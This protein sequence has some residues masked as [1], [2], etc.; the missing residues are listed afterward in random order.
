MQPPHQPQGESSLPYP[1][2]QT[3]NTAILAVTR[4]TFIAGSIVLIV[5]VALL[6]A[7]LGAVIAVHSI[8]KPQA[9]TLTPLQEQQAYGRVIAIDYPLDVLNNN[10]AADNCS[11]SSSTAECEIDLTNL[12]RDDNTFMNDSEGAQGSLLSRLGEYIVSPGASSG[13]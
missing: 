13:T 4:P 9:V 3:T 12:A 2:M 10:L 8:P 11:Y 6:S 1:T 7:F 5:V